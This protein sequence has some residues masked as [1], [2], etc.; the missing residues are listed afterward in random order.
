MFSTAEY[1]LYQS[2][3]SPLQKKKKQQKKM[4]HSYKYKSLKENF[5]LEQYC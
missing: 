1:K 5:L 3:I 4:V 2:D